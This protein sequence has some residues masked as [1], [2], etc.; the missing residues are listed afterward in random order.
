MN[1]SPSQSVSE[2][3]RL[4]RS[5]L[6]LALS[7]MWDSAYVKRDRTPLRIWCPSDRDGVPQPGFLV[8]GLGRVEV[9]SEAGVM[10]DQGGRMEK[11]DFDSLSIEKLASLE[12]WAKEM[13]GG[14]GA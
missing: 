6:D 13:F 8:P 4:V 12:R 5:I 2:R 10:L 11:T 9:L 14:R 1:L 3:R 7:H